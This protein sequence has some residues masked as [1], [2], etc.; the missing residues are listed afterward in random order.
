MTIEENFI[1][2]YAAA[3]GALSATG[4]TLRAILFGTFIAGAMDITAAIVTWL[5]RGVPATRVLQGVAGGLLGRDTFS[6]GASTAALGLLLHFMIM[7]VI[8]S[9]YVAASSRLP[10]LARHAIACGIAYGIV[11]YIVM[12]FVVVPLS[13]ATGGRPALPMILTGVI[14]H[15]LCVGVPIALIA[16]RFIS[17]AS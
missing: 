1:G 9:A 4:G 6:G 12:T 11:V 17:V 7:S 13:A 5:F 3:G 15:I 14:V 10:A 2:G 8:V 16:R